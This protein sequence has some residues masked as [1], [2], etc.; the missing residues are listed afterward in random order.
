MTHRSIVLFG[1]GWL[2]GVAAARALRWLTM[3]RGELAGPLTAH[4]LDA[5]VGL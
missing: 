3:G 4:D 2:L 5:D 1:F